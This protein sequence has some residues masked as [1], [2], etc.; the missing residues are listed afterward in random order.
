MPRPKSNGELRTDI[1]SMNIGDYVPCTYTATS[2][3]VGRFENVGVI[4]GDELVIER[5]GASLTNPNG[6]FYFI[7]VDKG[8]LIADRNIQSDISWKSINEGKFIEGAF[9]KLGNIDGR[10]RS[11]SG[12]TRSYGTAGAYPENNE[13]DTYIVNSTLDGNIIKGNDYVWHWKSAYSWMQDCFYDPSFT[14]KG[15]QRVLRGIHS[16]SYHTR[17]SGENKSAAYGFRPVFEYKELS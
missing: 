17:T 2:D 9:V 6:Y 5:S 16:P 11:L 10:I 15:L 4:T 1:E 8:L 12:G 14:M 3:K 13:W 7:K